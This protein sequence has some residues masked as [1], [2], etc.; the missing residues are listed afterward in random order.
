MPS[1]KIIIFFIKR[2]RVITI[3]PVKIGIAESTTSVANKYC[4]LS[5]NFYEHFITYAGLFKKRRALILFLRSH[6]SRDKVFIVVE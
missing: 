5:L 3:R 2:L 6:T 1:L 4:G